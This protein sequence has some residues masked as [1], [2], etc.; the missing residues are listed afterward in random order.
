MSEGATPFDGA[1]YKFDTT[2][3]ITEVL[4]GVGTS[5]GIAWSSDNTLMYY[6]DTATGKVDVFDF[7][8]TAGSICKEKVCNIC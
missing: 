5:N 8:A 1:L 7:N 2:D 6:N 4:G 3:T